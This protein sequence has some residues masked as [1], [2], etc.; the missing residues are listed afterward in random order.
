MK[1]TYMLLLF[2]MPAFVFAQN[3]FLAKIPFSK[4]VSYAEVIAEG[5]VM[6]KKSYWDKDKKNIYTVY[7]V[8]VSKSYKGK[9]T[10]QLHVVT[11]GGTVGLKA[12]IAR[13]SITLDTDSAGVFVTEPFPL[14]LD[15]FNSEAPLYR[16][17]GVSQGFYQYGANDARIINTFENFSNY[18]TLDDTLISLT[19]QQPKKLKTVNYFEPVKKKMTLQSR[20]AVSTTAIASL[21][22]TEIVAGNGSVL[23]ING[24]GFGTTV[25]V[26]RFNDADDAGEN[27]ID[28]L[29]TQIVSWTDSEIKV[30]VPGNAGTGTVEVETSEGIQYQ[31]SG[32]TITHAYL[33]LRYTDTDYGVQEGKEVEYYTHHIGSDHDATETQTN[34]DNGAYIFQ[35]HTDFIANTPAV[36]SFEDGFDPIVC[37][38]GINFKLSAIST[39][40]KSQDDNIN[41]ISF[42]ATESGILG[43]AVT[44]L[45]G[46][47][48][49]CISQTQC[50]DMFWFISEIDIVFNE[51]QNWSF[52]LD[53]TTPFSEFDF[54]AV[55]RHEVG[56]AAGLGHVINNEKIM[57]YALSPGSNQDKTSNSMFE[58]INWKITNDKNADVPN[59][60]SNTD[61]SNCYTLSTG[62]LVDSKVVL[63]PIPVTNYL[64]IT[65]TES[66]ESVRIYNLKGTVLTQ[67][68]NQNTA[69][70]VLNISH[71]GQSVYIAEVVSTQ[72]VQRIPFIKN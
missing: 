33:T 2:I 16:I 34:F 12:V 58:P 24:T 8:D 29:E 54:N 6:S 62:E 9:I 51:D 67:V 41:S 69:E 43:Q 61:F 50:T 3:H 32:L 30:E 17:I 63:Y 13:P 66:I 38:G 5:K 15:G 35:Y 44:R 52:D 28:A 23:T 53:G 72:G 11:L 68:T 18:Q 48:K 59:N 21:S 10:P 36:N 27:T 26:V 45:S 46:R 7:T 42:D 37:D 4:Q 60:L 25:G 20:N 71:Y 49:N 47:L 64:T 70:I 55:V 19:Q 31:I 57:H 39:S 65:A 1:R 22:P 14:E 56:H 40:A